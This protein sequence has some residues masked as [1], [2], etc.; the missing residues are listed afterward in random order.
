SGQVLLKTPALPMWTAWTNPDMELHFDHTGQRLASARVGDA[1]DRVGVW[2]FASGLEY[3]Y[4]V[5]TGSA[6]HYWG[7][8]I[9]RGCRLAAVGRSDGVA[10]FDLETG[11]ELAYVSL[12]GDQTVARFDGAGNLLTNGYDGFFR[13]PVRSDP[14]NPG[15]LS[16]GPPERLPFN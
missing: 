5:A 4:L 9:H 10:L 8:A 3:R 2:S 14:A 16:V 7:P 15:R 6:E 1:N 12:P 13:W 11:R